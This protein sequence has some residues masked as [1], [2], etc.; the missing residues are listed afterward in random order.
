M[1][2]YSIESVLASHS[3]SSTAYILINERTGPI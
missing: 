2:K 1:K 3:E